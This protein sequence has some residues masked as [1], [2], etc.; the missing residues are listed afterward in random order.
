MTQRSARGSLKRNAGIENRCD[1][2]ATKEFQLLYGCM[3]TGVCES[4]YIAKAGVELEGSRIR[5][6]YLRDFSR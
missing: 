3:C 1:P 6:T 4:W 5:V 2:N